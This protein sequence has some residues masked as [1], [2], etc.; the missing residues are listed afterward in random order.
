MRQRVI[1]GLIG[2]LIFIVVLDF[3]TTTAPTQ[4]EISQ[5]ITAAPT[6]PLAAA[7]TTTPPPAITPT[8]NATL[9]AVILTLTEM[10][11]IANATTIAQAQP[12]V[13][14]LQSGDTPISLARRY[15]VPVETIMRLNNIVDPTRLRVGETLLIPGPSTDIAAFS[16]AIAAD[17]PTP[18]PTPAPAISMLAAESASINGLPYDAVIVMPDAVQQHIREIYARGQ[19]LGNN[20]R[21]FSKLGDSTIEYPFFLAR[22]DEGPYN[23]GAYAYLQPVID[24]FAG[25]FA[26]QSVAIRRGLHTWSVLDPMWAPKPPCQPGEHMLAC[27][28][29]L[30]RP[31]ILFIRLGSNDAGIP[32]ETDASFRE[33]VEFAIDSGVIPVIGTKADRHEGPGNINNDIMRQVAAD[34]RIPLMDYDLVA[35]TVPGRGLEQDDVHMTTFYAHDYTQPVAFQRGHGLHNLTALITLDRIWRVLR[36]EE[37]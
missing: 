32:N 31:S 16:T 4:P 21:A 18:A 28:F 36:G 2:L 5:I 3:Q 10:A 1:I 26:R 29:R 6:L 30:H 37:T 11:H 15:N 22:F 14:V 17:P 27:E 19:A 24:Y 13:Y 25:S 12:I 7:S 9:E 8:A 33:I 23:L 34:Y 20:G 35:Q